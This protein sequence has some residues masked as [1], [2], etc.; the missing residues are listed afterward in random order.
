[1]PLDEIEHDALID[2]DVEHAWQLLTH[3]EHL[4]AWFGD[5]GAQLDLRPGGE[6][7]LHWEEHGTVHGIFEAIDAPSILAFRWAPFAHPGGDVPVPGNSTLVTFLLLPDGAGTRVKVVESGFA[8]LEC[9]RHE[10]RQH[11]ARN[12][13]GWNLELRH[14]QDLAAR[15]AILRST[16]GR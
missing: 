7:K 14:L 10:Q 4:G 8:G 12:R 11:A 15:E 6:L 3:A 1:M 13:E 9:S 2:T 16:Y 5:A